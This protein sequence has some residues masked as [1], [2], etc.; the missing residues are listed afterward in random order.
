MARHLAPVPPGPGLYASLVQGLHTVERRLRLREVV[1]GIPTAAAVA[2]A[3]AGVLALAAR[4]IPLL[5]PAGLALV[6]VG[7]L[8]G[9]IAL[10]AAWAALRRRA[11]LATARC[12]DAV[13]DLDEK[14]ATAV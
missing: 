13:L 12:A 4:F 14:T 10:W 2:F 1:E 8:V 5:P 3:L 9:V 11:L 6:A 7:L